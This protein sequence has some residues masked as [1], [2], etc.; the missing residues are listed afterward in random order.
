MRSCVLGL[1]PDG[2]RRARRDA[3][4]MPPS[5]SMT[6]WLRGRRTR[7]R[8]S[9]A[10]GP[11]GAIHCADL[12]D[13][14][15]TAVAARTPRGQSARCIAPYDT[16]NE[17]LNEG[18]SLQLRPHRSCHSSRAAA[19]AQHLHEHSGRGNMPRLSLGS[20]AG[21]VLPPTLFMRQ[22]NGMN[23]PDGSAT[24]VR[25]SNLPLPFWG[26]NAR[27]QSAACP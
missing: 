21:V 6:L 20:W 23:V 22:L 3:K 7:P 14:R 12:C 19:A 2:S 1:A 8:L 15:A 13:P 26:Q 27:I 9:R 18:R 16:L 11:Q 24:P 25:P 10:A 17:G 5:G 4:C